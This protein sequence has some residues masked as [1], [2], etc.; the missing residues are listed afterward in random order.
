[1]K[2]VFLV[3]LDGLEVAGEHHIIG[4]ISS[5]NRELITNFIKEQ[6]G[7]ILQDQ[8]PNRF[9]FQNGYHWEYST[10]RLDIDVHVDIYYNLDENEDE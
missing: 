4:F 7:L 1:M 5:N 10:N 6:Y 3:S 8:L 9:D 2:R